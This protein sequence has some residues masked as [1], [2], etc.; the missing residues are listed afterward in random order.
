PFFYH[1][2]ACRS[3]ETLYNSEY[4]GKHDFTRC[5]VIQRFFG[6]CHCLCV[7]SLFA[8]FS[9]SFIPHVSKHEGTK[10]VGGI[11]NTAIAIHYSLPELRVYERGSLVLPCIFDLDRY[12]EN[13]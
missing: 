13:N 7:L 3:I 5:T 6:R 1:A 4:F 11:L 10:T 9:L 2:L 12:R 8:R